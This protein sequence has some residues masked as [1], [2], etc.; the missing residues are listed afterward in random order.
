[1]S[2]AYQF[3]IYFLQLLLVLPL[4]WQLCRF[5]HDAREL[6]SP[7]TLVA[8]GFVGL[9]VVSYYTLTEHDRD[10]FLTHEG[11][12]K[13]LLLAVLACCAFFLGV[14]VG[15][16][17]TTAIPRRP[18]HRGWACA[19]SL[20]LIALGFAG[21]VAFVHKSG[22]FWAFYSAPHGTAGAWADTSAYLYA[23]PKLMFP[24]A[25][26]L[27]AVFVRYGLL[28]PLVRLVLLITL[29]YIAFHAVVFGNR[30][31]TIRLFLLF[32]LP[33]LFLAGRFRVRRPTVLLCTAVA[34]SA[35]LLFPYLRDALH[36]G[37]ETGV[38]EAT[39]DVF[40]G[41]DAVHL[42]TDKS[43]GHELF[44]AAGLVEAA[45]NEQVYDVGLSWLYPFVNLIPRAWWPDKPYGAQWSI[46]SVE[47]VQQHADWTVMYGAAATGVAN[48]FLNFS[49]FSIAVW[50]TLG[51]WGG[52]FWRSA[53]S[54]NGVIAVA[55]LWAY[56]VIITYFVTQGYGAAWHAWL[57]FMLPIWFVSLLMSHWVLPRGSGGDAPS[58]TLQCSS[59]SRRQAVASPSSR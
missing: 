36:L 1:M 53:T 26:I 59:T 6:F 28:S 35:V 14:S 32:V 23:L 3:L 47:L 29:A 42:G 37:A 2:G 49:W 21:L 43:S 9:Y 19:Y 55:Y 10:A 57:F 44:F 18:F 34:L 20:A 16:G 52:R 40:G 24:A 50:L 54:T 56:L 48:A 12:T 45:S 22:G 8:G 31:D 30:G 11:Y 7:N 13:L 46:N 27:Y 51:W 41:G 25:F 17:E 58:P 4:L 39:A 15:R 33:P 5:A 38:V